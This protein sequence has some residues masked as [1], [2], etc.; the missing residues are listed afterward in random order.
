M[1]RWGSGHWTTV[2]KLKTKTSDFNISTNKPSNRNSDRTSFTNWVVKVL[3]TSINENLN[4]DPPLHSS[5]NI[6]I[7]PPGKAA[8][9]SHR[10]LHIQQSL[11]ELAATDNLF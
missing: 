5:E 10:K 2:N 3:N 11:Q 9:K 1:T 8:Y 4:P 6:T 7:A